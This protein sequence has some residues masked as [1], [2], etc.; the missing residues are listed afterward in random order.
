MAAPHRV[1][2]N[3]PGWS[4]VWQKFPSR[5]EA[6]SR[7]VPISLESGGSLGGRAAAKFRTRATL[8]V[9]RRTELRLFRK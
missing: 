4:C 1:G 2:Q 6:T 3:F 8:T 7:L 9:M 5:V